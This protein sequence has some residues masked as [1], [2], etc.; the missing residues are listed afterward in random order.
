MLC[1][2]YF[3]VKWY[4]IYFFLI[5]KVVDLWMYFMFLALLGF[6]LWELSIQM[7]GQLF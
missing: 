3:I 4:L 5:R 7:F 2:K 1:V 6:F